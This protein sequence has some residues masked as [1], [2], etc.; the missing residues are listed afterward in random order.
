MINIAA[1]LRIFTFF[2]LMVI[3]LPS[4]SAQIDI[5]T[6]TPLEDMVEMI[7]GDGV[8]YD[9]VTYQ[10]ADIATAMFENGNTT[11]LGLEKGIILCS[12]NSNL[13]PGPNDNCWATGMNGNPG[14]PLLTA[15]TSASITY[16]AAVLEFD[17]IPESDTLRFKY[18]FGGE[19]YNEWIGSSCAWDVFGCLISGPDPQGG[20]YSNKNIAI[21]PGTLNTSIATCNINYG[22][23]SCG[24]IPTGPCENCEFYIDITN[25][26]T[27]QYDG[28]TTVLEAWVEVMPCE[29]YHILMGVADS[30][31]HLN[32]AGV[33]I[34]TS[35]YQSPIMDITVEPFPPD[36]TIT[37]IEG[38]GEADIVFKIPDADYAPVT[39]YLDFSECTVNPS[40]FPDG[41]FEETLPTEVTFEEGEDSLAIHVV[42]VKDGIPEGD[43]VLK[44]IVEYTLTCN[45]KY[46][47]IEI[48]ISDYVDMATQTTPDTMICQGEEL[49]LWVNVEN[50]VPA[51]TYEWEG[52]PFNDDTIT[53]SPVVSTMYFVNVMDI[54]QDT[55]A[56]SIFVL[57]ESA[58]VVNLGAD[59]TICTGDEITLQLLQGNYNNYLWSTGDTTASITV[60]QPG[61]YTL[62]VTNVC[63]T[64]DDEIIISQW[65][66]PDPNLGPD[67]QLCFG[68]SAFLEAAFGFI[69][70]VWQDNSTQSFFAV[71]N[72]GLYVVNV[73]DVNGCTGA[74]SVFVVMANIVQ[75]QDDTLNLCE[76]ETVN[77]Q[78]NSGFQYYTWSNGEQ[79]TDNITV[80]QGGWYKVS[81]SYSY[82]C[83]SEDSVYVDEYP[84]PEAHI[85]GEDMLCEGDTIWL[86]APQ[87]KFDYYWNGELSNSPY[88]M[89]TQG[90]DYYLT[91]SNVCGE[92]SEMKTIQLNLL[93]TVDLGEDKL[94][95][96]GEEITLDAGIYDSYIWKDNPSLNQRYYTAT[97][98]EIDILDSIWVEVFD[99]FCKNTDDIIIEVLNVKVP[100]LITPNGDGFNDKFIP[101][102]G[103]NGIKSHSITVFNRWGEIVWESPDFASGWDGKRNGSYVSEG[104]YFWILEVYFG[105][106]NVKKIYKG[107]LTVLGTGK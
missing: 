5:Q 83:P 90:G 101:G 42:P 44:I 36:T 103:W 105:S 48:V 21:V 40:A 20:V 88:Y 18:V 92:D 16:D 63:G 8:Y 26:I 45:P 65:P 1:K 51:Y 15:I 84:H 95:F 41:D 74:D 87:G 98:L 12:G 68:E 60:S 79:G 56:D 106:N 53:V 38:C 73:E 94:L 58:P 31:D 7:I 82:D 30:H 43:E 81:V 104:T 76:G 93:P 62:T 59:T 70:Y 72:G 54:C 3:L 46:D 6:A 67:L 71:E 86:E 107:T 13:I 50:G 25:G 32:D 55:V 91:L 75:L 52:L 39:A 27:L 77:I 61:A 29:S 17:F 9:N 69:S 47:T 28:F 22:F 57:V 24:N 37:L 19:K 80:D 33:F 96:P 89:V 14:H 100:N 49:E 23:A 99:G 35:D 66:Y 4:L 64:S 85:S 97:Y 11:N 78:A 2:C 102:E 10:G 34:E